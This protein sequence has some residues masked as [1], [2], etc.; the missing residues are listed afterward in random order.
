MH[1]Q[2]VCDSSAQ[3]PGEW[4]DS[5]EFYIPTFKSVREQTSTPKQSMA[6]SSANLSIMDGEEQLRHTLSYGH[7]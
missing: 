6:T 2:R 4:A 7:I 5:I 1:D 3:R